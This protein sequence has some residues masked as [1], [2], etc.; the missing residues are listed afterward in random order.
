MGTQIPN[1]LINIS[2]ELSSINFTSVSEDSPLALSI[3]TAIDIG[4]EK[5]FF[6]GF[7]GYKDKINRNQLLITKENQKILNDLNELTNIDSLFLLPTEYKNV[8][9]SSLYNYV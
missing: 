5:L 2:Y 1:E 6:I 4:V 3:Q 9:L 8:K 7:D